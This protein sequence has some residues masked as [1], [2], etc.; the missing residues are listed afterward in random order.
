MANKYSF[1][2]LRVACQQHMIASL[3]T[4][5]DDPDAFNAGYVEAV[6]QR[7]VL[8]WSVTPWGDLDGW[9]LRRTEDVLQVFM[10]DDYEVRLQMLLEMAGAVHKPLMEPMPGPEEDLLSRLLKL[11]MEHE[12]IVSV[13][14][15]EETY[16][17]RVTQVDDLRVTLSVFDFFGGIEGEQSFTLRDVVLVAVGTSEERMFK[18]LSEDRL[19]LV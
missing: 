1:Y 15:G 2:Q 10:G 3:Y 5:A 6:T 9:L 19:K 14:A 13:Q 4:E 8:L 11:A 17:G 16:T 12:E 18:R 7:H